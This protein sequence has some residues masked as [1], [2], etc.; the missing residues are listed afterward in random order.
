[1][2]HRKNGSA[3]K[4]LSRIRELV[5]KSRPPLSHN[6]EDRVIQKL[7]QTREKLWEAKVAPRPR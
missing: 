3:L 4:Q 2:R 7:R 1:M 5:L 6:T